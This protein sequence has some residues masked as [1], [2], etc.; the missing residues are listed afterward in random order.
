MG[1]RSRS[2]TLHGSICHHEFM[3]ATRRTPDGQNIPRVSV[4]PSSLPPA[5]LQQQQQT[6]C[7]HP[8]FQFSRDW[9]ALLCVTLLE[10]GMVVDALYVQVVHDSL[11]SSTPWSIASRLLSLALSLPLSRSVWSSPRV[12]LALATWQQFP[13]WLGYT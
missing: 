4:V 8:R 11:N 12:R 13:F 7:H 5:P 10:I 2:Y 3:T 6:H 9:G 1:V